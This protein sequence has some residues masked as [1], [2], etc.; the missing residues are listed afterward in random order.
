MAFSLTDQERIRL[1]RYRQELHE[2]KKAIDTA[3]LDFNAT[4]AD[5]REFAESVAA[6]FRE[7]FDDF[8]GKWDDLFAVLRDD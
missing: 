6:R 3:I 7:Q 5:L 1:A 8:T 4:R 2:Q